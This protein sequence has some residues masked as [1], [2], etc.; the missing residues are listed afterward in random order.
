MKN[1]TLRQLQIFVSLA[2]T[3]NMTRTAQAMHMTQSGVTQHI[4]Q[5]E[6]YASLILFDRL[7][8][9]LVLTEVGKAMLPFV[10]KVLDA[11]QQLVEE[12]A[13]NAGQMGG[14]LR[15]AAVSS[16]EYFVPQMLSHFLQTETQV[17]PQLL[18]DNRERV[19]Q[20][21]TTL[22][23]DIAITG[24]P[25]EKNR[26]IESRA[27]AP[28]R[29]MLVCHPHHTILQHTPKNTRVSKEQ[30]A[31]AVWLIREKG[32]GTRDALERYWKRLKIMPKEVIEINS[33]ESIK[34]SVMANLG[35]SL[36]SQSTFTH[37]WRDGRITTLAALGL[38][39]ERNWY[40]LTLKGRTISQL[41]QRF[42]DF[43]EQD[44][45]SLVDGTNL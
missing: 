21:L 20:A 1:A 43:V 14:H 31:Q 36:L 30:L 3:G 41:A 5:L 19:L 40:V 16:C 26:H 7:P 25:P 33:I 12:A 8:R 39:L 11:A 29:L 45:A 4:Q 10:Q 44:G 34:Q 27:F 37:E 22:E 6:S 18:M 15:L 32:S 23:V 2:K 35:I 24:R 38:P 13:R 17:T 42:I 28:N 9:G